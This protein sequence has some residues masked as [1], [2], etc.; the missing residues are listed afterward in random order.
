MKSARLF[1]AA[2]MLFHAGCDSGQKAVPVTAPLKPAVKPVDLTRFF[3]LTNRG[4]VKLEEEHL[5]GKDY[6]PGGNIAHYKNGKQEYDLFLLKT[7]GNETAA[8]LVFELKGKLKDPK[9]IPQFGGYYGLDGEK[10]IFVFPKL[11]YL[12]GVIG[13]SEKDADGIARDF[14]ARIH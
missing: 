2:A 12:A 11:A 13:L 6:L 10:K 5:L 7:S 9:F 14:A 1:V 8:L 3:P 4:E